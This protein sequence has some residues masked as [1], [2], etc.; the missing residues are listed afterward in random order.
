VVCRF[1][2]TSAALLRTLLFAVERSLIFSK[3]VESYLRHKAETCW[4]KRD[5]KVERWIIHSSATR[6]V[7]PGCSCRST[8]E[9]CTVTASIINKRSLIFS[10]LVDGYTRTELKFV[11]EKYEIT[12]WSVESD[13]HRLLVNT[14]VLPSSCV[15]HLD[16]VYNSGLMEWEWTNILACRVHVSSP[17]RGHSFGLLTPQSWNLFRKPSSRSGT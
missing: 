16:G 9:Y 17:M 7:G 11:Q 14:R 5:H 15:E 8:T 12:R 4:E 3:L 10:T 6:N 13:T 1:K 2:L